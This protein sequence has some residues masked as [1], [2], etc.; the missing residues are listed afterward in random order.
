[1]L[2]KELSE[3][4]FVGRLRDGMTLGVG[5]WATRRKPMSL[6]R[7]IAR[8]NL[9]DLTLVAP[10]GGPDVGLLAA[11]GKI[12]KLL[13][14]FVSL[15]HLPLDPHFRAGR[16]SGAF[17]VRELDEGLAQWSLRAGAMRLPFLPTR[18][19][20]GTD[21]PAETG[22]K[23]IRSPY[24]DGEEL[25]AAPAIR[26]DAAILHVHRADKLGNTLVLS[27]DPFFDD[28]LARAADEVY[29]S[30]EKLVATAELDLPA[31]ARFNPFERSVVTGVIHAP[32]GAHP[33]GATP[34]YGIDMDHLKTYAA[35]TTPEA[36]GDYRK[37]FVEVDPAAYLD[38]V[39]G[40]A[41]LSALPAPIY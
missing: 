33:T 21:V 7:A 38:A 11:S 41:R 14:A 32:F 37:R 39:G 30:T 15:D 19:G 29:V 18:V 35:A 6:V 25:L 8:S 26:V 23:T 24:E 27:P 31:N 20:L 9:K 3:E 4:A 40:G 17:E 34:D 5:G 1:M 10:Y 28:L 13:F 2:N 16:Q 22:M 12:R 36:W